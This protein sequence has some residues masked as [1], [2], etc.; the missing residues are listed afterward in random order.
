MIQLFIEG[1]SIDLPSDIA[2]DYSAEN[3]LITQADGYSLGIDIPH[4]LN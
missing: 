2:F 3:R 4:N 1:R